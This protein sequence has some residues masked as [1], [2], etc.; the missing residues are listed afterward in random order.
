MKVDNTRVTASEVSGSSDVKKSEEAKK[1]KEKKSVSATE[2]LG[3]P[4]AKTQ[5]SD[6]AKEASKIKA[7]AS[8]APEVRE[9]RVAAL[10]QRI[11]DGNYKVDSKA[12]A[13]KLVDEHLASAAAGA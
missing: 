9:E 11:A 2:I 12:I 3:A 6:K 7:A 8:A 1:T 13:D 5:I 4:A 10:K